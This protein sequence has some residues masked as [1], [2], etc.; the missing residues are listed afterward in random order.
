MFEG[1]F[2]YKPPEGTT[3]YGFWLSGIGNSN[4]ESGLVE[5]GGIMKWPVGSSAGAMPGVALTPQIRDT[6]KMGKI[7]RKW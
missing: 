5:S 4:V 6:S 2:R 1:F 7:N 3:S